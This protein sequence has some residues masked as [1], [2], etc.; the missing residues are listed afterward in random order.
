MTATSLPENLAIG[1]PA[2]SLRQ[3]KIFDDIYHANTDRIKTK[4]I[5]DKTLDLSV[6]SNIFGMDKLYLAL[7]F[8]GFIAAVL[9]IAQGRVIPTNFSRFLL[10]SSYVWNHYDAYAGF[11]ATADQTKHQE[12]SLAAINF[13]ASSQLTTLT[14]LA[15]C[16]SSIDISVGTATAFTGFSFAACMF[17]SAI[18]EGISA[19][20]C[21]RQIAVFEK[22][23]KNTEN[24]QKI[25]FLKA[26]RADHLRN[27]ESWFACGVAMTAI[28]C[29]AYFTMGGLHAATLTVAVF[30][31]ASGIFRNWY[32]HRTSNVKLLQESLSNQ[33]RIKLF[34][35][36]SDDQNESKEALLD[37][38]NAANSQK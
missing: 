3:E 9:T 6:R 10:I 20:T 38:S 7:T 31:V 15:Q 13:F 34:N 26:I 30:G 12:Y 4:S 21:R 8:A 25:T 29:V 11:V 19:L 14:A 5:L 2:L 22:L 28:A 17:A 24:T 23:E 16:S 37:K 33:N 27:A 18:I 1:L 32:A 35:Q 36:K